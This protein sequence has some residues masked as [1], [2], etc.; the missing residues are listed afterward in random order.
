MLLLLYIFTLVL[1]LHTAQTSGSTDLQ[2]RIHGHKYKCLSDVN[3]EAREKMADVV[4]SGRVMSVYRDSTGSTYQASIFIYRV[5][6]GEAI[7]ASL[8]DFDVEQERRFYKRIVP[9]S[10]FGNSKICDS[11]VTEKD[12]RIFLLSYSYDDNLTLS[13]SLVRIGI[14][15]LQLPISKFYIVKYTL[16][17]S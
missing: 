5:M 16:L 7:L 17:R 12:T 8:F 1:S 6:K 15:T 13:S 10:G 4:L 3:V 9:V 14:R 2:A 11:D